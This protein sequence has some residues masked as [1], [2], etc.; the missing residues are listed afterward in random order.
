[1]K[2]FNVK[3]TNYRQYKGVNTIEL[4]TDPLRNITIIQ[5]NNGEGKSNFM[6]AVTWCLYGDELFTSQTNLGR[7]TINESVVFELNN[8]ETTYVSVVVTIGN[9]IPEYQFERKVIYSLHDGKPRPE[10]AT[11][12]GKEISKTKGWVNL[13][14]PDWVIN[15]RFIPKDLRGFFFFDGEKM[16]NYFEDTGRIKSNVEK[17]AQIDT[18]EG[19]ILTL[20]NLKNILAREVRE[21]SKETDEIPPELEGRS[22]DLYEAEG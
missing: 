2:I 14:N 8:R 3:L 21:F 4:S 11:F 22:S 13:A 16:E 10:P 5:G 17:I 6:N 7:D 15:R 1:M 9:E 12:T 20:N 18:L 19:V